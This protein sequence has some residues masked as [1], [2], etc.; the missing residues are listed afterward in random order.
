MILV[1]E[2]CITL[3]LLREGSPFVLI[4]NGMYCT[5][6]GHPFPSFGSLATELATGFS[7]FKKPNKNA[8]K[9]GFKFVLGVRTAE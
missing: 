2:R 4:S 1:A 6:I 9:L 8:E 7:V 3:S 5:N